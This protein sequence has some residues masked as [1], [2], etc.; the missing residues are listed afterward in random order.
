MY[1]DAE[2]QSYWLLQ[3]LLLL[4]SALA[5]ME[6]KQLKPPSKND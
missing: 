6:Y 4:N 3:P 1:T 2:T 5:H